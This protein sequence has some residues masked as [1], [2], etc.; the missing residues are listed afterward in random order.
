MRDFSAVVDQEGRLHDLLRRRRGDWP[1]LELPDDMREKLA[2]W[3]TPVPHL[4]EEPV[5][6]ADAA[7]EELEPDVAAFEVAGRREFPRRGLISG[8]PDG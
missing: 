3:R 8:A 6:V 1:A 4:G 2:Q 5:Q 7:R